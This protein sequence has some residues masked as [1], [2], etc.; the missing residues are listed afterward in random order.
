M[1]YKDS[2]HLPKTKFPMKGNLA[3]KVEP[4]IIK[5]WKENDIL[6]KHSEEKGRKKY[7]LHDGPPYANGQIH[8]GH[9]LN[10]ILKDFIIK[11]KSMSGYHAPYIPGWDCHGLPIEHQT[12][13]KLGK[14]KRELTKTE[15][16]KICREYAANFVGIQ[17]DEFKRLG[18]FGRW[19]KPY[20]TMDQSY[21][22]A[23]VR[24]FGEFVKNGSVYKGFK[25][26][27]WCTSC[28]TALAE[29]EVEYAE[30]T[31]PSITVGFPI[32]GS[33][34]TL[35]DKTNKPVYLAIWTTTPWT[36]PA[37]MAVALHEDF[38][39]IAIELEDGVYIVAKEL[40]EAFLEET[41]NTAIKTLATIKGKDLE[42]LN[43][44][45][46]FLDRKSKVVLAAHV[47]ADGGTGCVHIAPGHGKEDYDT[48]IKYGLDIVCP[49]DKHG[50]FIEG[51]TEEIDG[52]N[53][54][55]A[56][57]IIIEILKQNGKLLSSK[58]I[59]HSYPHC[60]RC[61]KP[62]I[63]RATSQ[64]FISMEKND[65]RKRA[66]EEIKNVQWIPSWGIDRILSMVENR[67]DWCISRQRSW[68]VPITAFYCNQCGS[69]LTETKV[70]DH[71]ANKIEK[72]G[73]E[74]WFTSNTK[75]LLPENIS[76]S[77]CQSTSFTKEEDILDVWF[78]SGS[79]HDAVLEGEADHVWP[80]DLYLEGS[81]QHRGWFQSSLLI[82]VGAKGAAPFKN[83]L[84]HGFVVDNKGEKMSKSKGN[85][86]SPQEIVNKYGADT[87]RL[88]VCSEDYRDDVKISNEIISRLTESYRRIRNTCRFLLG[89]LKDMDEFNQETDSV[90]Y[91]DMQE[92]DKYALNRL[93]MVDK[94]IRTAY[95]TFEFHVI[96][97][98]LHN[99]C[100]IELS[101]FYLD[102]LKDRLYTSGKKSQDRLSAL[103][104]LWEI[105]HRLT[106]FMAP[107]L[108]FTAEEIWQVIR[109]NMPSMPESVLI[110]EFPETHEE[111]ND[112]KLDEK[113]QRLIEV[114][115]SIAKALEEA[116]REKTI[117]LSLDAK[118]VVYVTEEMERFLKSFSYPLERVLI[119][120]QLEVIR[121]EP[122]GKFFSSE[123]IADFFISIHPADGSKC[124][125][126]WTYSKTTGDNAE[127][128]TIC[129][130]CAKVVTESA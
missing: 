65:L 118:V 35:K 47:T 57:P 26:I 66:V 68:G 91:K 98:T 112:P 104:V 29:A 99:F 87:L 41:Q 127:H 38:D 56:N 128:P 60:W 116:R 58:N 124:E 72:D 34:D 13:K 108:S 52:L 63:F 84:T 123:S 8:I 50:K 30:H 96:Y 42:G 119:V 18:V 39:Y 90:A 121:A 59:S 12:D 7:I 43:C 15:Y 81:D 78:D 36:L 4:Q 28:C 95:E 2:L 76:C 126:C 1:D 49:V 105:L 62:V 25:P 55:K 33:L 54:H 73:I 113:W 100:N 107:V 6:K 117:G 92:I 64:W 85:V 74:V 110:A 40:K 44:K 53:I 27:H 102:I 97:H 16:R 70:I 37:N 82:G 114:K 83:V 125:R 103:T 31:S 88:W 46:P 122:T 109:S 71:V 80:A 106:C 69:I 14:K 89:N 79:S 51:T 24:Q 19:E 111:W 32:E 45:H 120:S 77:K 61:K 93:F 9:A 21:E 115:S 130:R 129:K 67:P 75:E 101:S 48:G 10:K 5:F 11:S 22:A 3:N 94:K 17:R 20:L 86:I 23:I